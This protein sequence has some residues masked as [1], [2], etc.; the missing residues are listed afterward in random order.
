MSCS[1]CK[2]KNLKTEME[3]TTKFVSSGIVIFAII[4]SVLGIYGLIT[5]IGKFL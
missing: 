1:T 4:W 2:Q 5:L 3:D